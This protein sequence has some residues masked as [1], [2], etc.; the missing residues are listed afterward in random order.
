MSWFI[1]DLDLHGSD[2]VSEVCRRMIASG[3]WTYDP[4][5]CIWRPR[6]DFGPQ[7]EHAYLQSAKPIGVADNG[8]EV[9][10]DSGG[11]NAPRVF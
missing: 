9:R 7:R 1:T 5:R 6:R 4:V 10:N 2:V 8:L 3:G 11:A